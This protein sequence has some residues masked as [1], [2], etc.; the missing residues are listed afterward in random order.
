MGF[1]RR[2]FL[3]FVIKG[4]KMRRRKQLGKVMAKSRSQSVNLPGARPLM[5]PL[6]IVLFIGAMSIALYNRHFVD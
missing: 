5:K 4:R 6:R 3:V 2:A 1:L